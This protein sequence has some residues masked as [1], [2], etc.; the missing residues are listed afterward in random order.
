LLSPSSQL[1]VV[2]LSLYTYDPFAHTLAGL[3]DELERTDDA[4]EYY[5]TAVSDNER[6][7]LPPH[8]ACMTLQLTAA[9]VGDPRLRYDVTAE[10]S[11]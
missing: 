2:A 11:R 5:K 8:L 4:A 9:L 3:A 7:G 1:R 6:Y 10:A